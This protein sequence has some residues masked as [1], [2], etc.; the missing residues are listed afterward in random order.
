MEKQ[1]P[2]NVQCIIGGEGKYEDVYC[3]KKRKNSVYIYIL[4][5][6]IYYIQYILIYILSIIYNIYINYTPFYFCSH[7]IKSV[8]EFLK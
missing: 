6:V 2:D 1:G 8:E 3:S 5:I 4:Y 7:L